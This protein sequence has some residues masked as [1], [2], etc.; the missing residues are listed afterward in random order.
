M[1]ARY[2]ARIRDREENT[3]GIE[4]KGSKKRKKVER[5]MG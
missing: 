4:W 1:Q 3:E 5:K 2:D